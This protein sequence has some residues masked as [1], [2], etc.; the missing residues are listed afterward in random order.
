MACHH[1][2][3]RTAAEKFLRDQGFRTWETAPEYWHK[4]DGTDSFYGDLEEGT[5]GTVLVVIDPASHVPEMET[6]RRNERNTWAASWDDDGS[7]QPPPCPVRRG[8]RS[9][10]LLGNVS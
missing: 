2:H 10:T 3:D 8:Q 4:R 6:Q 5:D 1:F 9:S 7:A